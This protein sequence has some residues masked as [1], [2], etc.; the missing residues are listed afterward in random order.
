MEILQARA[1]SVGVEPVYRR[2][3]RALEELGEADL[4]VGADGVNSLVR[5]C[6][7]AGFGTSIEY[8]SNRFAWYGTPKRFEALGHTFIETP[9]GASTR[10]ITGTR[11]T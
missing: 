5:R 11:R 9:L 6:G 1:R 2:P 3:I 7:E 8:F 10:I 4:I